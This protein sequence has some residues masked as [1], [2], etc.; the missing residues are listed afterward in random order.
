MKKTLDY[1]IAGVIA[2][3]LMVMLKLLLSQQAGLGAYHYPGF[4]LAGEEGLRRLAV[5]VI[6]GAGYGLL[7]GMVLRSLLPSGLLLG[8]LSMGCVPFLI[9]ALVLPLYHGQKALSEPWDLLW[10]YAQ[11]TFYSLCL[12]WIIGRGGKGGGKSRSSDDD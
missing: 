12:L 10:L 8:P 3:A 2:A 1:A 4:A 11:W 6:Y 9:S 7:Y 5:F